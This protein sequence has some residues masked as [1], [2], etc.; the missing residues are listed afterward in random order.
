MESKRFVSAG[1][2]MMAFSALAF[3]QADPIAHTSFKFGQAGY[4]AVVADLSSEHVSVEA[5]HSNKLQSFWQLTAPDRP[6]AAITG[7]FFNPRCGAPVG[8]DLV[9]GALV[10][11][12]ERGS[13][14]AVDWNGQCRVFDSGFGQAVDWNDYRYALRGTVRLIRDGKVSPDPRSQRFRDKAIWG[15]ARRTAAGITK[16]GKLV[17]VGTRNAVTLSEVGNA[18]K[19]LGVVDAVN[20]D[21]GSSTVMYY[22]GE[23]LIAPSRKLS[24]LLVLREQ[25]PTLRVPGGPNE[26]QLTQRSLKR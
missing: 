22:R 19:S 20:L 4:H 7:T 12:G 13:V 10:A 14:I 26:L 5:V 2:A 1:T 11:R 24:N 18:M 6:V 25:A 15:R 23:L 3:G 16:G 17:M 9:D 8:D 21:G